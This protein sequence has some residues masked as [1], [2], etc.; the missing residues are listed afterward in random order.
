MDLIVSIWETGFVNAT[1]CLILTQC[2]K[3]G[4]FSLLLVKQTPKHEH[5]ALNVSHSAVIIP[6]LVF[7]LQQLKQRAASID[8]L[9]FFVPCGPP[10]DCW[11]REGLHLHLM[12]VD[13]VCGHCCVC[14]FLCKKV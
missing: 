12:F 5:F 2:L 14:V 11:L 7:R 9:L 1:W 8:D 13:I 10:F 3:D 6:L 4:N